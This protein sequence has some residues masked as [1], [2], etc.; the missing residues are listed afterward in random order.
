MKKEIVIG[1]V[2]LL[3]ST[4]AWGTV[5]LFVRPENIDVSFPAVQHTDI[6]VPNRSENYSDL[7][8]SILASNPFSELR[9]SQESPQPHENKKVPPPQDMKLSLV[10]IISFGEVRGAL[11]AGPTATGDVGKKETKRF[12]KVG[13]EL[14]GN[15]HIAEIL[16]KEVVIDRNGEK[17]TLK[18]HSKMEKNK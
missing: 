11:F 10:G 8:N 14:N 17:I 7:N 9:G 13:E 3:V 16:E 12:Y 18:I 5:L 2:L 4:I 1:T 6:E 15:S